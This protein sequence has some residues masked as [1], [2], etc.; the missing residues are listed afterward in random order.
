[1]KVL[2]FTSYFGGPYQWGRDLA[3]ELQ[4]RGVDAAHVHSFVPRLL[5]L[6][7][8]AADV[9]HT[10][11]PFP[12]KLWSKPIL[13]TIQGNFTI[14]KNVLQK[15]YPKAIKQASAVSTSSSYLQDAIPLPRAVLIPNAV[16]PE[17]FRAAQHGTRDKLNLV[18]IM[19]F[20][21]EGKVRGLI[22]LFNLLR[23]C[24]RRDFRLIVT[25][26]GPYRKLLEKHAASTELDI[27]FTGQLDDVGLVLANSD[28]FLYYTHQDSFPNVIAEAM[29]SSLPVLTN[30]F[31][32]MGDIITDG[33]DGLI[34]TSP[35]H[36]RELLDSLFADPGYRRV[37]GAN[38]RASVERKFSWN[39]VAEQFLEIYGEIL[40]NTKTV[41]NIQER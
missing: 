13:L 1:M 39:V 5:G 38:A 34:A 25:G 21:F 28:A 16:F 17:R 29:A 27:I 36:Y 20:Y 14:E 37:L 2:I 24:G 6:I 12:V 11:I 4:S 26:E 23:D 8:V 10:T 33:H 18:T 7:H 3:Q 32:S 15:Y 40:N 41:D 9:L 35:E 22:D 30:N 31:G 19:N